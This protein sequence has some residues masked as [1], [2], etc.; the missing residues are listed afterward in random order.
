[1]KLLAVKFSAASHFFLSLRS[2]IFSTP[3]SQTFS[4]QAIYLQCETQF[5]TI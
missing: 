3:C 5:Y 2:K 1:M 4:I